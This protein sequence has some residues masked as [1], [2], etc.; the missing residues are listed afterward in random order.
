M[1]RSELAR[2]VA[3]RFR[4]QTRARLSQRIATRDN[5]GH[6]EIPDRAGPFESRDDQLGLRTSAQLVRDALYRGWLTA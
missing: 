5:G 3:P 4:L 1:I 6:R 2:P